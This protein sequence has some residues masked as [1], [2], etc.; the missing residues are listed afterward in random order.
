[1]ISQKFVDV[2]K[3]A[4]ITDWSTYPV[5]VYSKAGQLIDGYHGLTVLGQCGPVDFTKAHVE[6]RPPRIPQGKAYKV[7]VGL[8]F[9]SATWDGSDFFC[10]RGTC[11]I[12]ATQKAHDALAAAKL[13]NVELTL[14]SEFEI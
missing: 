7:H 1:L 9:D 10:P 11:H 2:L 3:V 14:T 6:F 13:S 5:E 4:E 8:P 12:V